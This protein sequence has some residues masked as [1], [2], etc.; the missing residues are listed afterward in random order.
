MTPIRY[1][2]HPF[3]MP[4]IAGLAIPEDL[5]W[6]LDQPAP[7]AGMRLPRPDA[8]WEAL[9]QAGFRR[10]VNLI[11]S[12]PAYDPRPLKMAFAKELQDLYGGLQPTDPDREAR[13]VRL[14]VEAS[15]PHLRAGEGIVVHCYGGRGRTGTVLG[16][17]LRA[18]GYPADEILAG[19]D[20]VH[21]L[22]GKTGWPESSWQARLVSGYALTPQ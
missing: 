19:L 6:V 17:V 1:L 9:Y 4:P 10:V 20:R 3:S 15:L 18:L 12:G 13:L 8:P 7:L 11:G 14:A 22:R 2:A 16:C 5:Y 21:K